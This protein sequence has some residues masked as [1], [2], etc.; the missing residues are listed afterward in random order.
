MIVLVIDVGGTHVKI[1][2]TGHGDR[3]EF[4]SGPTLTPRQMVAGVRRLAQGWEYDVVAIGYPGLVIGGR[5][6]REPANLAE[7]WIGY[8]FERAF[9]RPVRII[10]D[11]AM[12][13]LG[14][15]RGGTMLFLGLGTGLGSA[16]VVDGHVVPMELAH[17]PYRKGEI[18][19]YVGLRGL[20]RLGR[21][22]WRAHVEH[23]VGRF[24][25]ALH[26][27]EIVI[28]GGNA[29][30]LKTMPPGCRE[31]DNANAF[32]GGFR[33]WE[34]AT[35]PIALRKPAKAPRTRRNPSVTRRPK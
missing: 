29:K 9:G 15:Y 12:Q 30:K 16:L 19:D 10:N 35:P 34:G 24:T 8:D 20:E 23:L 28:G 18:E 4:E 13:A 33:M 2:A 3:R 22:R 32:A 31:G 27:D 5:I 7:G 25:L 26:P 1:L 6:V 21:K 14:S 17:L 11:A